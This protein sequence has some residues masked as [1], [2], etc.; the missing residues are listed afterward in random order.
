MET[1]Q[2]KLFDRGPIVLEPKNWG[3]P[4]ARAGDPATSHEAAASIKCPRLT[5]RRILAVLSEIGPAC[6]EEITRRLRARDE[7][8]S[9]SGVRG[10]RREL[11]DMGL[12]VDSG[13]KTRTDS[14]RA[15][16]VWQ[17]NENS[18]DGVPQRADATD[19]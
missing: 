3:P 14:G 16:V 10:R 19:A 12:V 18:I 5:H 9:P 2:L 15:S 1:A 8:T 13:R 4:S 17:V 6:D 7:F 11:V